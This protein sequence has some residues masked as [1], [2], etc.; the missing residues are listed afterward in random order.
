MSKVQII[1]TYE[2]DIN[3]KN[4]PNE[5]VTNLERMNCDKI[6]MKNGGLTFD[7]IATI[8]NEEWKLK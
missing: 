2:Y 6:N 8:V 4:Y 7:E 5:L 3:P 1:I